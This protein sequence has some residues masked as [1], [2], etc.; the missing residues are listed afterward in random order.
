MKLNILLLYYVNNY[1]VV[2]VGRVVGDDM[3][4]GL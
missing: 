2:L 3:G 4:F 1:G